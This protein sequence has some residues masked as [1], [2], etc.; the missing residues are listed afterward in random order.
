MIN[1]I[2]K[3]S[4]IM[5]AAFIAGM[6]NV[7][8]AFATDNNFNT[9]ST[10]IVGSISDAPRMLSAFS[11]LAGTMMGVLGVLKVKDHVENP[12]QAKLKDGAVRLAAGGALFAL[13]LIFQA[14]QNTINAGNEGAA[15]TI[16]SL[17]TLKIN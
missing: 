3:Q 9:I 15:T 13:P 16:D 11:Y 2:R 12:S 5:G 7:N 1:F 17:Q 6:M 4:I 14:M 10:N 8:D